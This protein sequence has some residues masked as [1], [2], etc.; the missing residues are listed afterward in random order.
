MD[1]LRV[2]PLD[3]NGCLVPCCRCHVGGQNWDR[4]AG[5]PYCPNCQ[6]LIAVGHQPALIERATRNP[7]VICN[8]AGTV[9]YL[10]FPLHVSAALEMDVCTEHLRG[11]LGR[12]LGPHAFHYLR[13]QLRAVQLGPDDIFLLHDEFYDRTGRALRPAVEA[14]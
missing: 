1:R 14:E 13:R 4:I 10:T 8:R 7:C 3:R 2:T 9:H 6:E 11:L 5:K 12:R